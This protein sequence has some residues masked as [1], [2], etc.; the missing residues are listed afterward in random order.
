MVVWPCLFK[1][2]GDDELIFLPHQQALIEE[3]HALIFSD[4]DVVIDSAGVTYWV[5]SVGP[6]ITLQS[7]ETT[8]NL[9]QVTDLIRAHEFNKAETC[10]T[11]IYFA[12]L[13]EAV[14]ALRDD[15]G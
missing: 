14:E 7:N 3:C 1:L 12:T 11:K 8:M 2:D 13:S 10:L 9:Q 5:Q 4:D 15:A 6:L